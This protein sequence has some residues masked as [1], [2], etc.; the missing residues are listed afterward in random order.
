MKKLFVWT[1]SDTIVEYGIAIGFADS[2][3]AAIEAICYEI[4]D[5]GFEEEVRQELQN[6]EPDVYE[7]TY[8]FFSESPT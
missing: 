5:P 6:N 4:E 8:G 7:E 1:I 2:V 3:E